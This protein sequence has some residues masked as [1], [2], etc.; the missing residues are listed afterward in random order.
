MEKGS[1]CQ[2]FPFLTAGMV[3]AVDGFEAIGGDMGV[4]LGG[5]NVRVTQHNLYGAQI[6]PA[7]QEMAG[8]GMTNGVRADVMG[9]AGF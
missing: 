7:F 3:A 2:G 8:K 5:G 6:S 9:N 4:D 1:R